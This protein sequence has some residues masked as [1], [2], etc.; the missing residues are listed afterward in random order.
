MLPIKIGTGLS[1]QAANW[2]HHLLRLVPN[3]EQCP[4]LHTDL[5]CNLPAY[6]PS[7]DALPYLLEVVH[8]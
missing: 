1:S 7:V 2:I 4:S 8:P 5:R 6:Q 3:I